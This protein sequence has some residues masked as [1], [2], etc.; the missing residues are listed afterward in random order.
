MVSTNPVTPLLKR[1]AVST[2]G[3]PVKKARAG[4]KLRILDE[5]CSRHQRVMELFRMYARHLDKIHGIFMRSLILNESY[6][7][8]YENMKEILSR[9][10]KCGEFCFVDIHGDHIP[11]MYD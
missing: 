6:D 4:T 8:F 3:A 10:D 7:Q 1:P 5:F 11:L 2:P 9:S